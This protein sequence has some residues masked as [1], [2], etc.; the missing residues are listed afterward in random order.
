MSSKNMPG[1]FGDA[2]MSIKNSTYYVDKNTN[3]IKKEINN[4]EIRTESMGTS[5]TMSMK[6]EM[7]FKDYDKTVVEE[8][9]E[10]AKNAKSME[11][12]LKDL[13]NVQNNTLKPKEVAIE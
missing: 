2:E 6:M 12:M 11:E 1:G 13:Q 3:L 5:V 9:P 10:E 7:N 8:L 4:I